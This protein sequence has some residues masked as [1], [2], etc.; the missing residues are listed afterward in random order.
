M[1]PLTLL[2]GANSTGKTSFMAM[3]RAICEVAYNQSIPDFKKEPF[4]L[5]SFD[6]MVNSNSGK[7]LDSFSAGITT[8]REEVNGSKSKTQLILFDS[9]FKKL[10][11]APIPVERQISDQDQNSIVCREKSQQNPHNIEI[12]WRAGEEC[13]SQKLKTGTSSEEKLFPIRLL[14]DIVDSNEKNGDFRNIVKRLSHLSEFSLGGVLFGEALVHAGAPIRS[15]PKRTY[16]PTRPARDSEGDYV[17]SLLAALSRQG[18]QKWKVLKEAINQFGTETRLFSELR[19]Q[20]KGE[21]AG[22]PFQI[23]IKDSKQSRWRNLMD[24]GYGINQILPLVTELNRPDSLPISLLQQPEVHL[25]PSAQAAVGSLLCNL[26]DD[27]HTLVVE[28]HSNHLINRVRLDIR[29]S[30]T[31]LTDKDVSIL[32][33]ERQKDGV[34]IHSLT[35]DSQGNLDAPPSYGS[36]FAEEINRELKVP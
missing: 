22:D 33:F 29:D 31:K 3:F 7:P 34:H 17:P 19:V 9:T 27:E 13:Y 25:H 15:K 14:A 11:T 8:S 28:T 30:T 35:V 6:D 1:A 10:D 4:D 2:V 20:T 16:D 18:G 24:V 32:Y 21:L 5:G 12:E 36:F 26:V 23:Q